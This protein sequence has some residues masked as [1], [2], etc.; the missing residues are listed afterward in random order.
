M[1]LVPHYRDVASLDPLPKCFHSIEALPVRHFGMRYASAQALI[2]CGICQN[3][4]GAAA[5][6]CGRSVKKMAPETG[7][8]FGRS[9]GQARAIA[10][11]NQL[12][13]RAYRP[14]RG[15]SPLRTA[16]RA[17][18]ISQPSTVAIRRPNRVLDG[19]RSREAV[20]DMS[21]PFCGASKRANHL[22]TIYVYQMPGTIPLFAW[23]HKSFCNAKWTDLDSLLKKAAG[24]SAAFEF[25]RE[26]RL[27]YSAATLRGGS[28]APESWIS[29][30]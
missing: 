17:L 9:S 3:V 2:R 12:K 13:S 1:R 26:F 28:S 11:Q 4:A 5:L 10:P 29:A 8:K 24:F 30:T 18:D 22:G 21:I 7:A 19:A 16:M 6:I 15:R 23:Q 14:K 27:A 25:I 20:L